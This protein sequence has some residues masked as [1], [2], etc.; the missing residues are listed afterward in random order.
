MACSVQSFTPA[1]LELL[2]RVLRHEHDIKMYVSALDERLAREHN[3]GGRRCI[4]VRDEPEDRC[5][6]EEE[7]HNEEIR[8]YHRRRAEEEIAEVKAKCEK[9]CD[10]TRQHF[11]ARIEKLL[12]KNDEHSQLKAEQ[13]VRIMDDRVA[14]WQQRAGWKIESIPHVREHLAWTCPNDGRAYEFEWEHQ[15]YLR[16]YKGEIW[17]DDAEMVYDHRYRKVPTAIPVLGAWVGI[18]EGHY[19]RRAPEPDL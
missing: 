9:R 17:R 11:E 13:L 14:H 12:L 5:L 16:T 1:Q 15:H 2:K 3:V 4:R 7:K 19:I 18:W 8:A 10:A 6:A